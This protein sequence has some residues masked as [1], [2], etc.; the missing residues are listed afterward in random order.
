MF[1]I[2][3]HADVPMFRMPVMNFILIA[4][5]VLFFFLSVG[6][7]FSDGLIMAMILNGWSPS[8]MLGHLL[9][10]GGGGHLIGNMIFLWVFGN[11]VSAKLGNGRFLIFYVFV[12]AVAGMTHLL[13]D[14]D[15]AIGASGAINGVVGAFLIW[16]PLNS[17]SC[18]YCFFIYRFGTFAMSSIWLILFWF[19]F[20]IWG[21]YSG[22]G[23]VAYFAHIGGFLAG[24][25]TATAMLKLDWV[26][27]ESGEQS[28]I[29]LLTSR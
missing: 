22:G 26:E 14:G 17:I 24:A 21:A 2:P 11:A 10:H 9:L 12:G 4:F 20:D 15:P 18:F 7:F 6:D 13:L 5:T 1:F 25:L 8:G 23:G 16:Y 3:Y 29:D 27:T 28:L 19:A